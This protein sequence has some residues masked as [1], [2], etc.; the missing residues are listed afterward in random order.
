MNGRKLTQN[1][2]SQHPQ[3]SW[4]IHHLPI[5]QMQDPVI[6]QHVR[7]EYLALNMFSVINELDVKCS[8]EVETNA[9]QEEDLEAGSVGV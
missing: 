9:L 8:P 5:N 2:P 3:L 7:L 1:S 6:H 4:Y